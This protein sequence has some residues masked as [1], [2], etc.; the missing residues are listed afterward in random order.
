MKFQV[1]DGIWYK[2]YYKLGGFNT[3]AGVVRAL[4]DCFGNHNLV[5]D[6]DW[7]VMSKIL[8]GF[9]GGFNED[10]FA[11]VYLRGW[12]NSPAHLIV[13]DKISLFLTPPVIK[14]I[15]EWM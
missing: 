10:I 12:N 9:N 13:K 11:E 7:H 6:F 2:E 8:G 15:E 1:D 5:N 14:S 3:E 4:Q